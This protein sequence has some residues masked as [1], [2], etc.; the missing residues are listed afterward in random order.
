MA[1]QQN[2]KSGN[3][4]GCIS[5]PVNIKLPHRW[6]QREQQQQQSTYIRRRQQNY[7]EILSWGFCWLF[8]RRKH[9]KLH[10]RAAQPKTYDSRGRHLSDYNNSSNSSSSGGGSGAMK[11]SAQLNW[12]PRHSSRPKKKQEKNGKDAAKPGKNRNYF[13]AQRCG[14]LKTPAQRAQLLESAVLE[15]VS[16]S[17][18]SGT[19]SRRQ[20]GERLRPPSSRQAAARWLL[21]TALH[22]KSY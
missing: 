13:F 12:G 8:W 22:Q 18:E 21:I 10:K 1:W 14:K 16:A 9:Q 4:I 19:G 6:A 17:G 20:E 5:E 2:K 11:Q 7:A 15:R 3:Q